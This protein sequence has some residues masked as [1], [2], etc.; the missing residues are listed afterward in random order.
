MCITFTFY[1]DSRCMRGENGK[2]KDRS[3]LPCI[4]LFTTGKKSF[5]HNSG[6]HYSS[7]VL[8]LLLLL[9]LLFFFSFLFYLHLPRCFMSF[10]FSAAS[11]LRVP[12]LL[13]LFRLHHTVLVWPLFCTSNNTP[14]TSFARFFHVYTQQR[15]SDYDVLHT[16]Y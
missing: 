8:L 14:A 9:L 13:Q 7:N 1:Y 2:V 15:F 3:A 16:S 5:K 10:S 4:T 6:F 12:F 11:A